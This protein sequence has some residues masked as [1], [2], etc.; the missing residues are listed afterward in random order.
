MARP[1]TPD[2]RDALAERMRFYR[3]LG[4][5]EFYRRPVEATEGLSPNTELGAP[6][7]SHLG[8]REETPPQEQAPSPTCTNFIGEEIA[9]PAR[10]TF[11]PSPEIGVV[12]APA[13]RVAAL[14]LIRE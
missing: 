8:T 1:L 12:V 13:E 3:D 7:P 14:Q 9:I 6:G 10:K 2:M 11:P 5:T 4:L